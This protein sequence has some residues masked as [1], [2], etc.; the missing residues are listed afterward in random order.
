MLVAL[1][2]SFSLLKYMELIAKQDL[3]EDIME[4][5]VYSRSLWKRIRHSKSDQ[6]SDPGLSATKPCSMS[7]LDCF[8]WAKITIINVIITLPCIQFCFNFQI[9]K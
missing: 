7:H 3:Y 9:F 2:N 8:F 6:A 5:P 4:D 1:Y